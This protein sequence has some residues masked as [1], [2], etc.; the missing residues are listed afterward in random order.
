M[1]LMR[2]VPRLPIRVLLARLV[3]LGLLPVAL[4]SAW[5]VINTLSAERAAAQRSVLELSRAL[6]GAVESELDATRQGLSAMGRSNAL[7]AGD[8]R[9]FYDEARN[10]VAA[11]PDWSGVI[12]TDGQ[13]R[14]LFKTALPFGAADARIVDPPSLERVLRT[15]APVVGRLLPGQSQPAA[16]PVRM[17]IFVQD[18]LAWVLTAA[19]RPDRMV[20][21]LQHQREPAGWIIAVFDNAGA[22]VA[23]SKDQASTVGGRAVPDLA[24]LFA[25]P[26]DEGTGITHTLEGEEVWTGYTRLVP[27]DWLVVVG[28]PTSEMNGAL[29]RSVAWYMAGI[30][31]SLIACFMLAQRISHRISQGVGAIRD[32]A[33]ELSE[34]RTVQVVRSP[35]AEL[36]EM[37]LALGA[38][39][40]RL[41]ENARS[42][43]E[44]LAAADASATAKDEFLAI[45]G[46]ELR[47]PLAPMLTA[48]Q[49]IDMKAGD[50]VLRERQIMRRQI[51]H[52]RR[53][54][55]D[56]LDVSRITRGK[57]EIRRD[58]VLLQS[59]VERS[60][61]TVEPAAKGRTQPIEVQLPAAPA[62]VAGE[63][64]RLIQAISNLLSNALR[65]GGDGPIRLTLEL[66]DGVARVRVEDEGVGMTAQTLDRVFEPFFQAP[67]NSARK[68]GGLGLGLAIVR[69]IVQLH[70]GTVIAGSAGPGR[71]SWFAIELAA[72][73]APA[74][75]GVPLPRPARRRSGRVVVVDDNADALEMIAEALRTA[76][77]DV[78][79]CASPQDALARIPLLRPEVAILD[80]GMPG[81]D[82]FELVAALRR[83]APDW[84]GRLVALTGYGQDADKARCVDAGFALHLTKPVDTAALLAAIE[85]LMRPGGA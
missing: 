74:V 64:A 5:A 36:D 19:V 10:E 16:Y 41:G 47:N 4:L 52:M 28:A 29:M 6:A 62:W 60:V 81:M 3:V 30:V 78:T 53:L 50:G 26:G 24:R 46:H 42:V 43:R 32:E 83:A 17:P 57:L 84:D 11:H 73:A 22:R 45:L 13:G 49:L 65:Y 71:G 7:A 33:V 61:E 34:G 39:S 80:L 2:D 35:I 79:A 38:A 76:G 85:S 21:V 12:L 48:L 82:G 68:I 69:S 56:L 63:E 23:R 40:E 25:Q 14:L 20:Q 51:D 67:Q 55:D 15:R 59:V 54:V 18:R 9:A 72:I 44:A 37:A 77:Y 58:A 27:D 66:A 75:E 1:R 8:V 70:G 31:G